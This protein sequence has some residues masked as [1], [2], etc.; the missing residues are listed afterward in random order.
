MPYTLAPQSEWS[1]YAGGTCAAPDRYSYHAPISGGNV[2]SHGSPGTYMVDPSQDGRG[3]HRGYHV[4]FCDAGGDL[5]AAGKQS[6]LYRNVTERPVTLPEARRMV[7]A[8]FAK[9]FA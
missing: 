4:M 3:R 2:S 5:I 1:T 8:D 6:G 9:Y 7:K